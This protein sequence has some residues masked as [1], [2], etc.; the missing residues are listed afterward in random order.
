MQKRVD[1]IN[2]PT[3]IGRIPRKIVSGFAA[4]T[5]DEWKHWILIY[6]LYA[7]YKLLPSDHYQCWCLLVETCRILSLPVIS[8]DQIKD[9]HVILV[10]FCKTFQSLYGAE[11][12][13]P[14]MHMACHLKDCMLDFGP[15]S[16]FW[17][18]PFER[19]NGTLE[20]FKKSWVVPEK[21][22][23]RKFLNF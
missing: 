1:S 14:N 19:Y 12:C 20:H 6:S 10:Q 8:D 3:K 21:Q 2:H 7:L 22:M 11:R 23:F 5:A 13:T 9:A 17:C 18:F 16:S 4:I 15:L